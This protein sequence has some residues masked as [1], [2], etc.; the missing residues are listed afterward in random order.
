MGI[1]YSL[2]VPGKTIAGVVH[3]ARL[4]EFL[5]CSLIST[6]ES[7]IVLLMKKAQLEKGARRDSLGECGPVETRK[8]ECRSPGEPWEKNLS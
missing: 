2:F 3:R 4:F 8:T 5:C 6:I 1:F 7:A